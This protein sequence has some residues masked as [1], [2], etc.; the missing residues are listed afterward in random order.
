M[1]ILAMHITCGG[2]GELNCRFGEFAQNVN[3]R[4]AIEIVG[5]EKSVTTLE[6]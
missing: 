5:V 1:L 2:G 6:E 3:M 4:L